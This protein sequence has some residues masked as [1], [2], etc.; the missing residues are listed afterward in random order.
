MASSSSQSG[1]RR[2]PLK[3]RQ[4]LTRANSSLLGT[5]K[6]LVTAPL[7]WFASTDDFEDSK[8]LKGKRRRLAAAPTE[9]A[10]EED[11]RSSRNKR[12]RVH[13]PPRD[14]QPIQ[15]PPSGD[16]YG[17][18]DPPGSAFQQTNIFDQLNSTRSTSEFTPAPTYDFPHNNSNFMR[19]NTLSRTM[20]ID[21]PSRPISRSSALASIPMPINRDTSM[22][23]SMNSLSLR[24]DL[25][26]PPLSGRPSFRMRASMTPVPQTYREVSEP[27]PI[28]TLVSKPMF[29]RGPPQVESH[30]RSLS[31]QPSVTL[32]S[33][34][35]SA[36]SVRPT[37]TSSCHWTNA[38]IFRL[39]R[40]HANTAPCLG[41]ILSPLLIA[42]SK[43][44]VWN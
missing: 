14:H 43:F 23:S 1:Q 2:K 5:I 22:D 11:D 20:S 32:G 3:K 28:N 37:M 4:P 25:S 9:P 12:L 19:A 31:R 13:S 8:D 40:L 42:V 17:Y 30:Q 6:N 35:E 7:A 36:R 44:I 41:P 33:L 24:R 16:A 34:V 10:V 39:V 21:P 27:P 15:Q 26:M 18:L 29:I 38:S